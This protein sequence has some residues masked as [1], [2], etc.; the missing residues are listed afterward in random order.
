MKHINFIVT[1]GCQDYLYNVTMLAEG[2]EPITICE[3]CFFANVIN[4]LTFLLD[5]RCTDFIEDKT[6]AQHMLNITKAKE[7]VFDIPVFSVADYLHYHRFD[8]KE[9]NTPFINQIKEMVYNG[10]I[11]AETAKK[12]E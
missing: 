2:F 10:D 7:Y 12:L 5:V 1:E 11:T 9:T 4:S 8:V 3:D 6:Y